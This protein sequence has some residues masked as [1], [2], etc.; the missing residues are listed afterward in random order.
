MYENKNGVV[1]FV[2][3]FFVLFVVALSAAAENRWAVIVSGASG[4]EKYAEQMTT[5]RS[6]LRTA[7]IDRYQFKPEFVKMIDK[8]LQPA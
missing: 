5:W 3:C 8:H 4:G 2:V 6:D 1:L 7:L